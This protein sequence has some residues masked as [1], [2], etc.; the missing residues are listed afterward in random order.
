M[1]HARAHQLLSAHLER[2]LD[3]AE[4]AAVE[5]HLAGCDACGADLEG[6]RTAV[7]LLRRLPAPAPPPFLSGR[8]MARI[9]DGEARP[10]G[11]R[12]WL[13]NL[14]APAVAA[15]LAAVVAAAAVV[16]LAEPRRADEL[17]SAKPDVA[18]RLALESRP[19]GPVGPEAIVASGVPHGQVLARRLR[20]AGHPHSTSLAAH[21]E[22]PAE[23]VVASWQSR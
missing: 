23:A 15:P 17:A 14:A 20:G 4:R 22:R 21:F 7:A 10:A 18:K 11:W 1:R 8:V 9:R 13:A 3:E 19:V 5:A 16:Y 12:E 2:D 6:L